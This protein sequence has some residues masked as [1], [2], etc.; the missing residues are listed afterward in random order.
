ME[1]SEISKRVKFFM[2]AAIFLWGISALIVVY[3]II[4][5]ASSSDWSYYLIMVWYFIVVI[6]LASTATAYA[7]GSKYFWYRK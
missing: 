2:W 1:K 7:I 5:M 4:Y 6:L 3:T